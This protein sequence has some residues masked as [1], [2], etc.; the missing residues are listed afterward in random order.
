MLVAGH[1]E[2]AR[3]KMEDAHLKQTSPP[4]IRTRE[5]HDGLKPKVW[6]PSSLCLYAKRDTRYP[7][8]FR[9]AVHVPMKKFMETPKKAK[10]QLADNPN[11]PVVAVDLGVNRPM[12]RRVDGGKKSHVHITDVPQGWGMNRNTRRWDTAA[13]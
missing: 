8:K 11:I 1:E 5:E 4:A 9:F 6:V 7:G 2:K 3:I 10:K 12:R 13:P